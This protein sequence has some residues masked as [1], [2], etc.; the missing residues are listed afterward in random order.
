MTGAPRAKARQ[1]PVD[2]ERGVAAVLHASFYA[3]TRFFKIGLRSY[4]YDFAKRVSYGVKVVFTVRRWIGATVFRKA[5]KFYPNALVANFG[6]WVE[7]WRFAALFNLFYLALGVDDF[8]FVE[9]CAR[10]FRLSPHLD[11]APHPLG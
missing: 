4:S 2:H 10:T 7:V 1:T 5:G 8:D 3:V 11:S 9:E 6:Q